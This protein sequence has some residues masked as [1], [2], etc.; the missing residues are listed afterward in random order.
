MPVP[1]PGRQTRERKKAQTHRQLLE[2]AARVFARK[3]YRAASVDDVAAEAGFTK[4]AFYS[5]FD[6]KEDVFAAL[7]ED[8]SR[9]W[10]MSVASAY[11][12]GG[13]LAERMEKGADVL[14][15]MVE[16]QSEW[17]LLSNEMWSYSVR[18]E[19]LRLRLAAAYEE[20]REII[21][22]LITTIQREHGRRPPMSPSAIATL[23]IAMTDGFVMQKLADPEHLPA[24]L[25]ADGLNLF[26]A[27]VMSFSTEASEDA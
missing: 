25:L 14:T 16:E 19:K 4:G 10:T 20:C 3:G 27:A 15:T 1:A 2:A 5:N 7:V 24:R 17:M 21:A 13:S 18:E 11:A 26:F 8:R 6:S 9:N 23:A 12:T 22:E